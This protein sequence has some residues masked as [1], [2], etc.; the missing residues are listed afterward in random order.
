MPSRFLTAREVAEWLRMSPSWVLDRYED[1]TL[2]GY[3]VSTRAIRFEAAEI[4]EWLASI[5]RPGYSERRLP[6]QPPATDD[7]P[8]REGE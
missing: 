5:R 1:G 7:P 3:P 8:R 6:G 2:P 4:E